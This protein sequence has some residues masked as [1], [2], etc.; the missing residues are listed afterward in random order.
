MLSIIQGIYDAE[1]SAFPDGRREQFTQ[2][3]VRLHETCRIFDP[4]ARIFLRDTA[5][6]IYDENRP[7]YLLNKTPDHAE[8]NIIKRYIKTVMQVWASINERVREED[9]ESM[10][11]IYR[12]M[13][14][15]DEIVDKL[16]DMEVW[17]VQDG[18]Q[19]T[20]GEPAISETGPF[21]YRSKTEKWNLMS[22]KVAE[23]YNQLKSMRRV[24]EY[25]AKI[26]QREYEIY[27]SDHFFEQILLLGARVCYK[28]W[29]GSAYVGRRSMSLSELQ[30]V[31]I[32]VNSSIFYFNDCS[33]EFR[34]LQ[35]NK[36]ILPALHFL[37][38]I[39]NIDDGKEWILQSKDGFQLKILR[40]E[41]DVN[42]TTYPPVS[43]NP[44]TVHHPLHF[45]PGNNPAQRSSEQV[46]AMLRQLQNFISK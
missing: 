12:S 36:I 38:N 45:G 33:Y 41:H 23:L 32:L 43:P 18:L 3:V 20:I 6:H 26:R 28:K 22:M 39:A 31:K 1:P 5:V 46:N 13:A 8:E 37:K 30:D 9:K 16:D 4:I 25:V 14:I 34:H 35:E 24:Q 40:A 44:D 17:T 21:T 19:L 27:D 2:A 7:P 42:P 15:L 10:R 29:P 11:I